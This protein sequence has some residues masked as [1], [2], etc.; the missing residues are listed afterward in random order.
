MKYG[1]LGD[2]EVSIS[3]LIQNVKTQNSK[4]LAFSLHPLAFSSKLLAFSSNF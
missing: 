2:A 4:L 3:E 1:R